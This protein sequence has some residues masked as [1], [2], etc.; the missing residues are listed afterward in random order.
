MPSAVDVQLS[1]NGR[2]ITDARLPT[3]DHLIHSSAHRLF[4]MH[5]A[6]R[7]AVPNAVLDLARVLR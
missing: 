7:Q 1:L 6:A 5:R 2:T 4:Q 3:H